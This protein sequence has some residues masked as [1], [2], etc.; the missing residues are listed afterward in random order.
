MDGEAKKTGE[1]GGLFLFLGTEI[2]YWAMPRECPFWGNALPLT[3]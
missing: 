1:G 2:A 3:G